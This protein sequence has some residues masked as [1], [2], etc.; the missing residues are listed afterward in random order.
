MTDRI[1][2][3]TAC[4]AEDRELLLR[5]LRSFRQPSVDVVAVD[6]GGSTDVKLALYEMS[7]DISIIRNE[8]NVYVYPAWNQ[9]AERFLDSDSEIFVVANADLAAA[10]GW[11]SSLLMRYDW[12]RKSGEQEF[13]FGRIVQN[14]EEVE[15]H[16]APSIELTDAQSTGGSFFALTRRAVE[17]A[18]PVPAEL[19]IWYGDGWIHT[20]L[21][22]AGYRGVA[23][24]DLVCWHRG[25]VSTGHVHERTP[26][27]N[28]EREIWDSYLGAV[29]RNIGAGI[30]NGT[31]DEIERRFVLFRD[32]PADIN[33]H[34]QKLCDYA[35]QCDSVTE[36]GIGRST[37]AFLH[38]RP[39][40]LRCYDIRDAD[41][42]LQ[43]Q[44]AKDAGI[45]LRFE[46]ADTNT[47]TIEPTDLLFIDTY[48][49][50]RQLRTEL[51]RHGSMAR[52]YI[53]MH[54]TEI[55]GASGED[56]SMPGLWTAVEEFIAAHPE[57]RVIEKLPNNNGL[58]V[59][60]RG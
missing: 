8:R 42:A 2:L 41:F 45:D 49:V 40:K 56:G 52:K 50:Y 20:L 30:R 11:T 55:F 58:T 34:M 39:K 23:L 26:I 60:Q 6:N 53:V 15:R 38:A 4:F 10:Q 44:L 1:M 21:S 47:L 3:G 17:L 12:A 13:W 37:W 19:L 33:E 14:V 7:N 5:A 22:E 59:L 36:F 32:T 48:H 31:M 24:R 43:N 35:K 46:R 29:C 27:V 9:L 18:F 54:N 25:G 16:Y 57:W 51:E 28:R